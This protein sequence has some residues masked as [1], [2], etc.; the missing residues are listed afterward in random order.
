[1]FFKVSDFFFDAETQTFGEIIRHYPQLGR[2]ELT[3]ALELPNIYEAMHK[4]EINTYTVIQMVEV[5]KYGGHSS[6]D[7]KYGKLVQ[8]QL[9]LDF[10]P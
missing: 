8:H 2:N 3:N 9:C 6:A 4:T 1:M 5:K 7:M 10:A